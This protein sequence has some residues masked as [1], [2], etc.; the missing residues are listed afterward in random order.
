MNKLALAILAAI[1]STGLLASCTKT[2]PQS[3][4]PAKIV[5]DSIMLS[6]K[7]VAPGQKITV[8]AQM[9]NVGGSADNFTAILYV[10]EVEAMREAITLSCNETRTLIWGLSESK[11]GQHTARLVSK[12]AQFTVV[13]PPA[14]KKEGPPDSSYI[15]VDGDAGYYVGTGGKS[16]FYIISVHNNHETW[17]LKNVKLVVQGA[18]Q[19]WDI[20]DL[21]GPLDSATFNKPSLPCGRYGIN[22]EWQAPEEK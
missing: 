22:Y 16:C 11:I 15:Q 10:D 6:P 4:I 14:S 9:S 5:V 8:T 2:P 21:I 18:N 7:E 20:A 3:K 13:A 19:Q 17:S 1:L 12:T